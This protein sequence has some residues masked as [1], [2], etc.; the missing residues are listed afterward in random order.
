MP[1]RRIPGGAVP[2]GGLN[3]EVQSCSE[4][5]LMKLTEE[6]FRE[7]TPEERAEYLMTCAR[8]MADL[9]AA[10]R[11]RAERFRRLLDVD[12]DQTFLEHEEECDA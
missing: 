6:F 3:M 5:M 2:R 1:H 7:K 12:R 9:S 10:L 8:E 11:A 4:D